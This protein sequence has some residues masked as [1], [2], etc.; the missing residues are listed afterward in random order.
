M[1]QSEASMRWPTW[2]GRHQPTSHGA[3]LIAPSPFHFNAEEPSELFIPAVN[4]TVGVL[5]S[6]KKNK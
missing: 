5:K 2:P 4:G 1:R 6:I 3:E